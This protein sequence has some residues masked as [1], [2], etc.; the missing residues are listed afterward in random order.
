MPQ[1]GLISAIIRVFRVVVSLQLLVVCKGEDR[2]FEIGF[3]FFRIFV[4][5]TSPKKGVFHAK[6]NYIPP[7]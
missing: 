2:I 5:K 6:D 1:Y 7:F 3:S 4:R